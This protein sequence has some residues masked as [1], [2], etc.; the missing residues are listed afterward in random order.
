MKLDQRDDRISEHEATGEGNAVDE[1]EDGMGMAVQGDRVPG[2]VDDRLPVGTLPAR[3][4]RT[5][6]MIMKTLQSQQV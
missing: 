6:T 3:M 5:T 1:M 2:V 4:I